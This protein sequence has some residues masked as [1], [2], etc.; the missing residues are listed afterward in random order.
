[1][2]RCVSNNTTHSDY[3]SVRLEN[4]VVEMWNSGR[5]K[6][7]AELGRKI[8]L[9]GQWIGLLLKA[10]ELRLKSK[11]TYD[12]SSQT[13]LDTR[14]LKNE[15]DQLR[16]L[17]LIKKNVIKPSDVKEY[18]K[19]LAKVSD[20]T[21]DKVL[22]GKM[23]LANLG[24]QKIIMPKK[25]ISTKSAVL[26]PNLLPELYELMNQ[27]QDHVGMIKEEDKLKEAINYVKFYAGLCLK[28]LWMQG[29]IHEDFFKSVVQH[30]L[31][32]DA[33]MLHHFDGLRTK[34]IDWWLDYPINSD[35]DSKAGESIEI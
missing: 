24:N 23:P 9:T 5:Y 19:S 16:L 6:A 29:I 14:Y 12:I 30:E 35:G 34:G 11:V 21:R 13:I 7:Y 4:L 28:I 10:R 31:Q 27:L 26:N 15:D 33:G 8:G 32:I 17:E 1:M 20:D 25:T 2:E 22:N 18:A 3:D